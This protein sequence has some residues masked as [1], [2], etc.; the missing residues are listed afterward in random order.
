MRSAV[1]GL[2]RAWG[3]P[4]IRLVSSAPPLR[5]RIIH[6][7]ASLGWGGQERRIMAEMAGLR[8]RGHAMGLLAPERSEVLRQAREQGFPVQPLA[9]ER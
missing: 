4:R 2:N 3:E 6:S 5:W 9:V 1:F 8:R 7:E